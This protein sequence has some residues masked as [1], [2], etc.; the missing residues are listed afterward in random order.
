MTAKSTKRVW[1]SPSNP[2]SKTV[3][4]ACRTTAPPDELRPKD[5]GTVVTPL[6]RVSF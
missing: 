4:D 6:D 5:Q 1:T 2:I 3:P